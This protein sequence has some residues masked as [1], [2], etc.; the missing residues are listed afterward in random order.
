MLVWRFTTH[1]SPFIAH[2]SFLACN[3]SSQKAQCGVTIKSPHCICSRTALRFFAHRSSSGHAELVSASH[4]E[5]FLSFSADRSWNLR[6][7]E[8]RDMLAWTLPSVSKLN[9]VKQVQ[10]DHQLCSVVSCYIEEQKRHIF[11]Q[12]IVRGRD[13][14][15]QRSEKTH[16]VIISRKSL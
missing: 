1:H 12:W 10:D 13:V 15:V 4:C 11:E 7:S 14:C 9:N 6:L 16:W 2:S 8:S 5:P 3:I